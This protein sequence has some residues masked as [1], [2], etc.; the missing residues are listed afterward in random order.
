MDHG[1]G[2]V[3]VSNRA[4]GSCRR[5]PEDRAGVER[6]VIMRHGHHPRHGLQVGPEPDFM[7]RRCIAH[8]DNVSRRNAKEREQLIAR[9]TELVS[10]RTS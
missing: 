8:V 10:E 4:E 3:N 7:A 6:E 2:H 1:R 9:F 5:A